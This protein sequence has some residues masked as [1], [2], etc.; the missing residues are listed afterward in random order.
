MKSLEEI[1]NTPNLV[2]KAEADNDG[3]GGYYYDRFNSFYW[4]LFF[5][6]QFFKYN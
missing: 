4:K 1:K 6:M 5:L 2:I 3:I